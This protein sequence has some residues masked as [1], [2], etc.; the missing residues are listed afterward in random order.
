MVLGP[1]NHQSDITCL[2][3]WSTPLPFTASMNNW[4][5]ELCLEIIQSNAGSATVDWPGRISTQSSGYLQGY[6]P[7]S[8]SVWHQKF[9]LCLHLVSDI[10]G[11]AHCLSSCQW[12]L[13]TRARLYLLCGFPSSIYEIFGRV[14][15]M[16]AVL[17]FL[18]VLR[19][20]TTQRW[21]LCF[22]CQNVAQQ[23]WARNTGWK[24]LL[25]SSSA[26]SAVAADKQ[27]HE[28]SRCRSSSA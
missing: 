12:V 27:R 3:R 28:P 5:G 10:P 25:K 6:H 17:Q 21:F 24:A 4:S 13:L 1:I 8:T 15:F 11:C 2:T 23:A 14:G 22:R 20:G 19:V 16:M 9:F 26:R 7:A 18:L